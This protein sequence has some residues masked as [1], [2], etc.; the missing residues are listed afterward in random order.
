MY[1]RQAE[2]C[3]RR[4]AVQAA[5]STGLVVI[6][7][8]M[9][10]GDLRQA[11][12]AMRKGKIQDRSNSLKHAFTILELLEGSLDLEKGGICAQSLSRFYNYIRTQL[13]AAQFNCDAKSLEKQIV[14]ILD[15]QQAWRQ[16]DAEVIL[17][18]QS[19][20]LV[21]PIADEQV[22]KSPERSADREWSA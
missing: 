22:L 17:G 18:D 3:Y 13:L 14:L 6:L 10:A 21:T 1:G 2:L 20:C 19:R 11:I 12:T 16:A 7:Y 9:L 5:T 4:A 8:D 15:V